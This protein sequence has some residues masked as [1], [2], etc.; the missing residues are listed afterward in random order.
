MLENVHGSRRYHNCFGKR[1][2]A[3]VHP[4]RRDI[5]PCGELYKPA[6]SG[7]NRYLTSRGT[8]IAHMYVRKKKSGESD[9]LPPNEGYFHEAILCA[10][11]QND[12]LEQ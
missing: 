5:G 12:S 1:L 7:W 10:H 11:Y 8:K 4:P 3:T 2:G 9:T 6:L